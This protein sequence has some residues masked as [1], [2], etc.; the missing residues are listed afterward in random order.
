MATKIS[1]S[2]VP[3]KTCNL[4]PL[5]YKKIGVKRTNTI[6][7]WVTSLYLYPYSLL[8]N[9]I[10]SLGVKLGGKGEIYPSGA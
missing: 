8:F 4:I 1:P 7:S 2:V 10:I 6:R 5:K 3:A 9:K